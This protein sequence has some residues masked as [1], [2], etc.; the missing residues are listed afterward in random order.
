MKLKAICSCFLQE[1][2]CLEFAIQRVLY[3]NSMVQVSTLPGILRSV[4]TTTKSQCLENNV[5][6]L[7]SSLMGHQ[8]TDTGSTALFKIGDILK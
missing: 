2:K 1:D 6:D 8:N 3:R 5:L 4:R 7:R